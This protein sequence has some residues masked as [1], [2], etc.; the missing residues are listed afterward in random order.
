METR[1]YL[2][3]TK[4][5]QFLKENKVLDY[6]IM[7]NYAEY[8]SS[9]GSSTLT[10]NK[11]VILTPDE[12]QDIIT[13]INDDIESKNIRDDETGEYQYDVTRLDGNIKFDCYIDVPNQQIDLTVTYSGTGD[14]ED[15]DIH[16][17]AIA[18]EYGI[19][20]M[21]IINKIQKN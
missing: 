4:W 3:E 14:L 13:Q 9:T 11:P 2:F 5:K 12:A 7:I 10:F 15:V 18:D 19:T 6:D 20:E 1:K 16:D 8:D 17:Q 21:H